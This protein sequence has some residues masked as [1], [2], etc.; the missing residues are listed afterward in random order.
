MA[1]YMNDNRPNS[2]KPVSKSKAIYYPV[3][4]LVLALFL[5]SAT[6]ING[7]VNLIF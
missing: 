5:W 1:P 4:C 7:V 2:K 6:I 3:I